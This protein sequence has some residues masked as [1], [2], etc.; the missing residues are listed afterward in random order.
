MSELSV[1]FEVTLRR[2]DL[3]RGFLRAIALYGAG[4][5]LLPIVAVLITLV[6][7]DAVVAL[8]SGRS[9]EEHHLGFGLAF[10]VVATVFGVALRAV[11]GRVL[12]AL[13]TPVASYVIDDREGVIVS[14]AGREERVPFSAFEGAASDR[15]AY[16]LYT[17]RTA[18]RIIPKRDLSAREREA[19]ETILTRRIPHAPSVPGGRWV[20]MAAAAGLAALFFWARGF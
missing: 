11:S 5:R 15:N 4:A 14:A 8:A 19:L 17:S 2:G 3:V 1:R 6:A 7:G 13:P 12:R 18:F 10:V 16:Y 9:L 20:T